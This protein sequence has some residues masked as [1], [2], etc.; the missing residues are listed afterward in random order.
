MK[1]KMKFI[2]LIFI[3]IALFSCEKETQSEF[4]DYPIIE[5]YL[6]SD[7]YFNLTITRQVPFYSDVTYSLDDINNLSI[8]V[9]YDD[10]EHTLIPLGD[11][12]YIDSSTVVQTEKKYQ[13]IFNY[14]EKNVSAYTTVP[15]KPADFTISDTVLYVVQMGEPGNFNPPGEMPEPLELTWTNDD[16]SYYMVVVENIETVLDPIM[17]IDD[18]DTTEMPTRPRFRNSP[19]TGSSEEI[20]S[21]E[22]EYYGTHRIILY[23]VLPDYASL[24]DKTSTS[25]QNLT[26]PSVSII[27]GYGIFTG[28]NSDTL[29]LEVLED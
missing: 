7:N 2:L 18:E 11:G 5:S 4:T 26:N 22:F 14:N 13:I 17:E 16:E 15:S 21:M 24:Y 8:K 27:N 19:S 28:L 3:A 10:I 1:P 29:Y 20:R 9:V 6:E 25:S 23:H 12:K